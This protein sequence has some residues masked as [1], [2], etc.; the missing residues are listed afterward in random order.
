MT[1]VGDTAREKVASGLVGGIRL[2][3]FKR[4]V[5]DYLLMP[6]SELSGRMIRFTEKARPRHEVCRFETPHELVGSISQRVANQIS[7]A[8]QTI[9]IKPAQK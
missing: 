5:L 4:E 2:A 3:D 1:E 8:E 6:T 7:A 9:E